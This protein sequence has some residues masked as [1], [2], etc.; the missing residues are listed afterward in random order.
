MEEAQFIYN[1]KTINIE[2][3]KNEMMKDI[4]KRFINK[5]NVDK[6]LIYYLYNGDIVN[7]KLT[8]EQINNENTNKIKILVSLINNEINKIK[9]IKSK[10]IIC[11][12]CKENA[13]IKIE[14]Y[15]IKLYECKNNHII[16]NILLEKYED[17]QK[18][19]ISK[20]I[21][22]ICKENNKSI[23]HNNIF[24]RCNKCK[25]NL[26]PL[27]KS[28]HDKNH[29]IV[30]YELKDYICEEHNEVYIEYCIKCKKNICFLC[31]NNHK[32]HKTI[33][34]KNI[35]KDINELKKDI[36]EYKKEIDI[37]NNNIDN[38]KSFQDFIPFSIYFLID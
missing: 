4:C 18:I 22:D 36:K 6:N 24:Y 13:R 9:I 25:I 15:K 14:D 16:Y 29:I 10:N 20:I 35:I 26:C 17:T 30:N 19:D 27:C 28:N 23:S 38:I 7:E 8:F 33:F 11:P 5:T 21:C 2:C 12:K 32:N 37:F 3:K 1:G 34:F 31:E